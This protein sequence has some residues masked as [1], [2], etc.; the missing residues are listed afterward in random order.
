MLLNFR[1]KYEHRTRNLVNLSSALLQLN[2]LKLDILRYK[3][4]YEYFCKKF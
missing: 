3:L 2:H 4:Y 1:R